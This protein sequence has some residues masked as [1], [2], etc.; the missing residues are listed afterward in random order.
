MKD[1]RQ[2]EVTVSRSGKDLEEIIQAILLTRKNKIQIPHL[3]TSLTNP[4]FVPAIQSSEVGLPIIRFPSL[5]DPTPKMTEEMPI[6]K[7]SI[8]LGSVLEAFN[9]QQ[10]DVSPPPPSLGS[11]KGRQ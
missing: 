2:V 8:N 7:R 5:F 10:F 9:P 1:L 6:Q 11:F 3:V 4:N